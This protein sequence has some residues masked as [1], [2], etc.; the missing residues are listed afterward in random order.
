[1]HLAEESNLRSFV[2]G[3]YLDVTC[4]TLISG[5]V[6]IPIWNTPVGVQLL[7][8][9][10]S[11]C[12]PGIRVNGMNTRYPC[13]VTWVSREWTGQCLSYLITTGHLHIMSKS[14]LMRHCVEQSVQ[15]G[16]CDRSQQ[17]EFHSPRHE[18]NF[19]LCSCVARAMA[20]KNVHYVCNTHGHVHS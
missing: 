14:S 2:S 17:N 6:C 19:R 10:V 8:N 15:E 3:R 11:A 1:M 5:H 13:H 20:N 18:N 4:K 7:I 16:F 12:C 9:L